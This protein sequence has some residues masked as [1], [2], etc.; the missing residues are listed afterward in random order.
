MN[1][2]IR[3]HLANGII[4]G[5]VIQAFNKSDFTYAPNLK[6]MNYIWLNKFTGVKFVAFPPAR[7]LS[8]L[9]QVQLRRNWILENNKGNQRIKQQ[10]R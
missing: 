1:A 4:T 10:I 7:N 8:H 3:L 9:V 6:S 5:V 2:V